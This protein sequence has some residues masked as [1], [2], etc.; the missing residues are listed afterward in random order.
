[1]NPAQPQSS[2]WNHVGTVRDFALTGCVRIPALVAQASAASMVGIAVFR[3]LKLIGSAFISPEA[4][5]NFYA[6]LVPNAMQ[7]TLSVAGKRTL[8]FTALDTFSMFDK[9]PTK[10]LLVVATATMVWSTLVLEG[11]HYFCGRPSR[12]YN[13][14]LFATRL[15]VKW[16]SLTQDIKRLW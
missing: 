8:L 3:G 16:T 1:M 9:V 2:I 12:L 10:Q 5:A 4:I 14:V 13:K 11:C 15:K 7:A 6:R